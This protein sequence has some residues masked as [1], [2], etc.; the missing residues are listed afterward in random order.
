MY[1]NAYSLCDFRFPEISDRVKR[2]LGFPNI[3]KV[4]VIYERFVSEV[5]RTG[6]VSNQASTPP[7]R[8]THYG[9]T[10]YVRI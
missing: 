6:I 1:D 3:Q 9:I 10:Y 2:K 5:W 8:I 7:A 4:I